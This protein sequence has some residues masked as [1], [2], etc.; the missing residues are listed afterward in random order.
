MKI[1]RNINSLPNELLSKI[2]LLAISPQGAHTDLCRLILVCRLWK[3]HVEDSALLW[4]DIS[5][6]GGRAYVRRALEKSKA[7]MINLHYP[8]Y[9]EPHI[10]L[11]SFMT[12]AGPHI[13]RWRSLE[14]TTRQ[15]PPQS[16]E[17]TL[18]PLT[19]AQAPSLESLWLSLS[20][21]G[22]S[23]SRNTITL[24]NGASA[25][26]TLK[27]LTLDRAQVALEPLGLS[28]LVSLILSRVSN[29]ST[30]Q[31]LQIVRNSPWLETLSLEANPGLVGIGSQLS[32]IPPIALP[33]LGTL[34][35]E[36][37]D[38]E[39]ANCILS[40]IRIPN[41]RC[42]YICDDFSEVSAPSVLLTPTIAHILDTTIPNP[43]PQF[44]DIKV[45]VED[46]DG[47]TVQVRGMDLELY[48]DGEHQIQEILGWLA[49]GLRSEA[50]ACPVQLTLD[51][52]DMDPVRLVEVPS[53]LV[54]KQLSIS[55]SLL[56][57]LLQSPR[58]AMFQPPKPTSSGSLLA[59]VENLSVKFGTIESQEEFIAVLRGRYEEATSGK[60]TESEGPMTLK[61]VELRGRP[62]AEGLVE[63][64]RGILVEVNVFWD[65]E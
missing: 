25:P 54:I 47:C 56:R 19:T 40:T 20:A 53:P 48:V 11:G 65:S 60:E 39:G 16:L 32:A 42:V 5:A 29:V 45:K 63:K 1:S 3:E 61:S 10:E 14:I 12:E 27:Y 41:R 36:W 38:H 44:F 23:V 57:S 34:T 49:E 28:S 58:V 13:A 24:F 17:R 59:Q 15:S 18:G 4:V 6:R 52:S 43:D 46:Y 51:C 33:K 50:A 30:T 35:L 2:F 21:R 22:H 26:S 37:I 7:S 8:A 62:R 64:L 31:I 9:S 55:E